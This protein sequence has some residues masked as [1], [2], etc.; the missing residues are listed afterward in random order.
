MRRYVFI[1]ATLMAASAYA[2]VWDE[3]AILARPNSDDTFDLEKYSS[4]LTFCVTAY[5]YSHAAP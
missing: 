5:P 4:D 2:H 3:L 1:A